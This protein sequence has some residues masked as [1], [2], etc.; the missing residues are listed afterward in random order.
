[1]KKHKLFISGSRSI[2]SLPV[3]I[4]QWLLVHVIN[5]NDWEIIVGD[6]YGVDSV[7]QDTLFNYG[8]MNVTVYHINKYPRYYIPKFKKKKIEGTTYTAKD[9]AMAKDC[10]Q[11][12]ILWD[13]KSK[14]SKNNK[15]KLTHLGKK[16]AVYSII[17]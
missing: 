17:N 5:K 7:I 2:K 8:F 10:D 9:V 6:C 16:V 1:M 14:G 11:G 12:L 4:T 15:I 13:G 3:E